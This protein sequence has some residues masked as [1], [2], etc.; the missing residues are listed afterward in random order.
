METDGATSG[1]ERGRTSRRLDGSGR[2]L[3]LGMVGPLPMCGCGGGKGKRPGS[4]WA[5]PLGRGGVLPKGK[6]KRAA[7]S[8]WAKR[9]EK[10][11][12][13][14]KEDF[15]RIFGEEELFARFF[16]N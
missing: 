16:M 14:G 11:R 4:A 13:A 15:S 7:A 9:E 1:A 8:G 6:E 2:A 5:M 12:E 3:G 10:Q